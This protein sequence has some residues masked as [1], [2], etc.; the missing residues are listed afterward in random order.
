MIMIS[1]YTA[2]HDTGNICNEQSVT[3]QAQWLLIT[4]RII[5]EITDIGLLT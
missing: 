1:T 4:N 5:I 3:V 2:A